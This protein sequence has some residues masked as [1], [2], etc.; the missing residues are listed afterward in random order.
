M[1]YIILESGLGPCNTVDRAAFKG[2][3]TQQLKID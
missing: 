1:I 2:Q 3:R